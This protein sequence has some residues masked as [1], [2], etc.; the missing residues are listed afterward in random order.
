LQQKI[1]RLV[2]WQ[3]RQAFFF[4]G[5][6]ILLFLAAGGFVLNAAQDE[7][8]A[9]PF[10]PQSITAT[11]GKAL[12]SQV[13]GS[14]HLF[15]DPSA[16]DK[17]T[18]REQ[19]L[20]RMETR[21]G[22]SPPDYSS[23]PEGALIKELKIY[24]EQPLITKAQWD[25]IF[26]YYVSTAP[27]TALQQ[28]PHAPIEVGLPQFEAIPGR[29]RFGP[30]LTTMV[31]INP[32]N[33]TILLGDEKAKF[34]AVLD[35]AGKMKFNFPFANVPIAVVERDKGIY[36]TGIGS[37]I[38]SEV[39]RA[40]LSY[41]GFENE[42]AQPEKVILKD[43]PRA[44]QTVFADFNRDGKMDF[45]TC[46]FGNLR[47]RFSWFENTGA[48]E[49]KEH[50]L[51]DKTGPIHCE[52]HD[53]NHD[54]IPDIALLVAQQTEALYILQND[55]NGNFG[56]SLVFQKHPAFGHNYF[57]LADF[58][59]DA[60]MDLLVVNGDNGEYSS[61][62]KKYHGV[63]IYLNKG[64]GHFE[65]SYFF[66]LNGAV[67]AMARDFDGDGDLDIA[68]ISF[69]PDYEKMPRESF[70]YLENKGG[71]NFKPRT[72]A[73][74]IAGRWDAMDVGD[75]DG[76]GDLDIVLGSY[77]RGPTPAPEMLKQVWEKRGPSIMILKNTLRGR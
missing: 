33:H 25:A 52:V 54:G 3:E 74:C 49:Y 60:E 5:F 12:A 39:Q 20:P 59:G 38:P 51:F 30:A 13:C 55:G 44:V 48:G 69:F 2:G 43:L 36:V 47:G 53:F 40:G 57:E 9:A 73:E 19:I 23:S 15:P 70:V 14:C 35:A 42:T 11:D 6:V 24:P 65:E 56:M 10:N 37:F 66:P 75:L 18:W 50:I 8:F 41:I 68:A 62:L 27:E 46:M 21:L 67:K 34:I 64:N 31:K 77:I 76:D 16:V 28:D 17:K 71:M 26:N 45:A 58:N 72:F 63:R 61:P 22:V 7:K 29:F 32:T 1:S 4:F